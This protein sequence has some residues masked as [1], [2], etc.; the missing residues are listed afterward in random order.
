MRS[1]VRVIRWMLVL[2]IA[3]G[4]GAC[5][6]WGLREPLS[7]TVADLQPLEVGLLEQRYAIKVRVLNPN[8]V[9]IPFEGVAFDIDLND[10]PFAKGVSN[11]AGIV[12][13]FGETLIDLTLVSGLQNILRQINELAKGDRTGVS[14]RIRG[15]LHSP[16][17]PWPTTFD[18]KGELAFPAGS[19]KAGS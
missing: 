12:P 18:T 5:A 4:T 8:D 11:R 10:K 2:A 16:N 17:V 1:Q 6:A 7:V 15:R 19:G 14:Y 3:L 9:D 13:R